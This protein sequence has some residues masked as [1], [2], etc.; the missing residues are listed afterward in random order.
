MP[1][2][3]PASDPGSKADPE[4]L[5]PFAATFRALA[6]PMVVTDPN[7]ADNPIVFANDAFIRLT[8]YA[9]EEAVGRNCRFLQGPETD[10]EQ[11][12][13]IREA[14][15]AGEGVDL[16]I[17][18]Y[19]K[20][21]TPFWNA[22]AISP[23]RDGAGALLYYGATH[24]DVS[25][26]RRAEADRHEARRALED[27]VARRTQ[28]LQAALDHKTALVREVDHRVKNSLQVV[29]SL[30]LLK[31][32]RLQDKA[33]QR[34]MHE[35]AGRIG[36]L[37]SAHRLLSAVGD[38]SRFSVG[39]FVADLSGDLMSGSPAGQV[40]LDLAVEPVAVS[41]AK[42]APIALLVNELMTNALRHAF[43]DER[44]G[45]L[46][47]AVARRGSDIHIRVEDD[48]VGMPPEGGAAGAP[49]EAFGMTLVEMLVRQLRARIAWEDAGPGTRAVIVMP[50]GPEDVEAVGTT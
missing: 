20:D 15:A 34:V 36:A 40:E 3:S 44:T 14:L 29:T 47:V 5:D 32:R 43:P 42:A 7:R 37:S 10:P 9:R 18:N 28:T 17:L 30:V 31:A 50:L 26:R 39:E 33:S 19:R 38:M 27:E 22:L 12:G 13:R 25:E 8:G 49:G 45:R 16:E 35:M 2:S 48:G 11:V 46:S 21:G 41:A 24:A 6:T 4:P 1:E 23:V